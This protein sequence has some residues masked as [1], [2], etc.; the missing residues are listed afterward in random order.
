ML[1]YENLLSMYIENVI[2]QVSVFTEISK[3]IPK[4]A[5]HLS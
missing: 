4:F 5:R 2:F 3:C 1:P